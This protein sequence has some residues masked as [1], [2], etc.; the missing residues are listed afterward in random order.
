MENEQE[1]R[2]NGMK[3]WPEGEKQHSIWTVFFFLFLKKTSRKGKESEKKSK[4]WKNTEE[5]NEFS[6]FSCWCFAVFRLP[7]FLFRF[8]AFAVA[9]GPFALP[10]S[11][12]CFC[13]PLISLKCELQPLGSFC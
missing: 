5:K 4:K 10:F 2:E 13:F 9:S 1:G 12:L 7:R 3:T 8:L 11:R 6:V